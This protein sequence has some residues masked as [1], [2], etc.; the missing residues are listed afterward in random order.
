MSLVS[1]LGGVC[2]LCKSPGTN[3]LNCPLNPNAKKASHSKHPRARGQK[4]GSPQQP[5]QQSEHAL[6]AKNAYFIHDNGARPYAVIVKPNHVV[7]Y[8]FNEQAFEVNQQESYSYLG[9]I[10]YNEIMIG[11][12]AIEGVHGN[13]ILLRQGANYISIGSNGVEPEITLFTTEQAIVDYQSPIGPNDVPYPYAVSKD[14]IYLIIENVRIPKAA[15]MR[16]RDDRD[17][18][19]PY[20]AYYNVELGSTSMNAIAWDV[21]EN[22]PQ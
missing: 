4:A 14:Y 3:K 15:A 22:V 6:A 1:Q 13:T 19:W 2:S 17:A 5:R 12:D 18:M 10:A 8:E 7:V 9:T 16:D 11:N 21:D 20:T